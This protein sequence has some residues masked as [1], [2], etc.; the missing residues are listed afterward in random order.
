MLPKP[1]T[2]LKKP[3]HRNASAK[4]LFTIGFTS[5]IG[6]SENARAWPDHS[7]LRG[8]PTLWITEKGELYSNSGRDFTTH[9]LTVIPDMAACL[10]HRE[11]IALRFVMR[12]HPFGGFLLR[13]LKGCLY[14]DESGQELVEV[15][16]VDVADADDAQ[17]GCGGGAEGE[18]DEGARECGER[19][20][21]RTLC[22]E[23]GDLMLV[24]GEE[25]QAA[26]WPLR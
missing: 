16:W 20:A 25:E 1:V 4:T 12:R 8:N 13:C 24:D 19:V 22:E 23:E 14:L 5:P 3:A 21:G 2:E 10:Y 17:V 18:A 15:G 7:L 9:V 11:R 26:G 6:L